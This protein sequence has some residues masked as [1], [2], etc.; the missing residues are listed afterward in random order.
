MTL[1]SKSKPYIIPE[2]SL[3]GDLLPFLTCN[4]QYRYQN[5]GTLPPSMPRQ[6]WFGEFIHGVME[7]SYL[8]WE[9]NSKKFP[10][11]WKE[12]VRPIEE[13][14]DARLR[15][16]GLYPPT[17]L[18]CPY[19]DVND[20]SSTCEDTN[21]P[22]KKIASSR[23][24]NTINLWGPH[25]FPL[26]DKAEVKVTNIRDMPKLSN[27]KTRSDYY[28][29]SGVIDVLSSINIKDQYSSD[30]LILK[31]LKK[32]DFFFDKIKTIDSDEFE[33]IIDYKGMKR[34]PTNSDTWKYH[35]WQISTYAW[36]R[37]KQIDSKEIIAGIIF[38]INELVPS[39]EDILAIKEEVIDEVT[40]VMPKNNDL[41]A[42]LNWN[43]ED[44][45]IV[46][47][48]ELRMDRSIRIIGINEKY[49]KKALK[50]FDKVVSD[51]EVSTINEANGQ[52]I[53]DSWAATSKEKRTCN[54]CDFKTF[55]S[56]S[57]DDISFTIP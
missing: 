6:L 47:S 16:K 55:C 21:H 37:S 7:E 36:L 29:V 49:E 23:A 51:I 35:R 11:A 27:L 43:E 33:I 2:Y 38:Y 40:D 44:E 8:Q 32:E 15:V 50:E 4:L 17:S 53:K 14:I 45:Y 42:I 31:Y 54:T 10:W 1:K 26:I 25:L 48:E 19:D 3:T 30:N 57:K 5:K 20:D 18:F 52:T 56:D 22:H 34:P 12:T 13:L 28:S 41:K 46:F 9:L 39:S 24:E